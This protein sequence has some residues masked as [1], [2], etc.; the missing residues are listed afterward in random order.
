MLL[1]GVRLNALLGDGDGD[2]DLILPFPI[3]LTGCGKLKYR[4]RLQF[5]DEYGSK[6]RH[7]TLY[8]PSSF[9]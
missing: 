8:I 6:F 4:Q 2:G 7:S 5:S 9:F 1:I 3:L